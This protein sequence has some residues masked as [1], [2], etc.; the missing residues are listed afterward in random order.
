MLQQGDTAVLSRN[1][2][3]TVPRTGRELRR[4]VHARRLHR[5]A[6]VAASAADGAAAR[7][8]LLHERGLRR[9]RD[10]P[11][12]ELGVRH[13]EVLPE[14]IIASAPGLNDAD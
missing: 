3:G 9:G 14:E 8:D 12:S 4:L 5:A 10:L 2:C 1:G 11:R 13:A 7:E 6:S